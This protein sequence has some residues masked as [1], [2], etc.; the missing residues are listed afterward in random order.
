MLTIADL[1]A[2][3]KLEYPRL[4]PGSA[5]TFKKAPRQRKGNT[6]EENQGKLLE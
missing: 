2:G 5:A 1:L 4:G 6:P 3:K